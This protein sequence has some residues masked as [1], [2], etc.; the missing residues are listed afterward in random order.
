MAGAAADAPQAAHS[1]DSAASRARVAEGRD[2]APARTPRPA[3]AEQEEPRSLRRGL[4][5]AAAAL[6]LLVVGAGA[7]WAYVRSQYYVGVDGGHVAVFRGVSGS[8]AGLPLS[9]LEERT[10]LATA[11]LSEIETERLQEGIVAADRPDAQ[12]IVER[13][14]Q[15]VADACPTRPAAGQVLPQGCP[16]AAGA[17][18]TPSPAAPTAAPASVPS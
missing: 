12:R 3:A 10:A 13:L 16:P 15:A 9:T 5:A 7:G 6:A 11:Q 4:V 14:E 8:V 2:V 17:V 18:P 1:G